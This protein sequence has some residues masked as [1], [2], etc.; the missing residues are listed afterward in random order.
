MFFVSIGA[1][2]TSH[3]VVVYSRF[4]FFYSALTLLRAQKSLLFLLCLSSYLLSLTRSSYQGKNVVQKKCVHEFEH[5]STAL[6]SPLARSPPANLESQVN[7]LLLPFQPKRS[8]CF[9]LYLQGCIP[10][11]TYGH[12]VHAPEPHIYF[13]QEIYPLN[14]W[15]EIGYG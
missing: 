13:V 1:M 8:Y 14:D 12:F 11:S 10:M 2:N 15:T 9:S 7:C 6:A 3:N 4:S 5:L